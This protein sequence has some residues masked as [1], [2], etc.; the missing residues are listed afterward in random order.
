MKTTKQT[1][2]ALSHLADRLKD[3]RVA[4]LTLMEE[5]VGLTSRP[6]TALQ[7]DADGA[8]W[9]MGSHKVLDRLLG[10]GSTPVNLAFVRDGDSD[11]A[12]V[13]GH[14]ALVDD[15]AQK[16]AL[17]TVAGRPWFSGP[18]DPDLVL[19]RFEPVQAEVWD[20]PDT[21]VTRVL[22]MAASVVAGRE[23]GMGTKETIEVGGAA[24]R[25]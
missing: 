18:A 23:V 15:A 19:I 20:G 3:H 11:Y 17:W 22:A 24:A 4:M 2:D 9:F 6:M 1:S 12:S 10:A 16:D 5:G 13:C 21:A 7:M 14:A 25:P 8:L